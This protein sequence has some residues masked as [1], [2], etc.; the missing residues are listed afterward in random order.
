MKIYSIV[1]SSQENEKDLQVKCINI[2]IKRHV[3]ERTPHMR[4]LLLKNLCET[5]ECSTLALYFVFRVL[6][7][8]SQSFIAPKIT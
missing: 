5:P 3:S 8:I 4:E 2:S 1:E 7:Y 6:L